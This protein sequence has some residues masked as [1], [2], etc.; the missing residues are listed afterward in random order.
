MV[1]SALSSL[2]GKVAVITGGAGVIGEALAEYLLARGANVTLADIDSRKG[3]ALAGGLGCDFIQVDV[4]DSGENQRMIEAAIKHHGCLDLVFL[5][6]GVSSQS[7]R[8]PLPYDPASI[9]LES[10]RR[11]LAVNIDGPV[12]GV[13]AAIPALIDNGGGAIVVTASVAGLIPWALDPVYTI[14]KHGLVGYIRSLAGE[15]STRGITINAICPG[16]TGRPNTIE[17]PPGVALLAPEILAS[18]MVAVATDGGTG[19]AASVV[20]DREPVVQFFEFG[21]VEGF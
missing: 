1:P 9:D 11:I 8:A 6:A 18:A 10:Y 19:R 13:S 3:A 20:A 12:F 14:S 7:L 21:E 16:G 5:N 2:N 15:L 4:S 17:L